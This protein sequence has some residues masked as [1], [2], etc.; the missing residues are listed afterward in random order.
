VFSVV[1]L[2]DNMALSA[3]AAE[4]RAAA[5]CCGAVAAGRPAPAAVDRYLYPAWRLA[6]N[7]PHVA[8]SVR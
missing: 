5:P 8:A 7:P 3:Y 1:K 6:A 2:A 4:R